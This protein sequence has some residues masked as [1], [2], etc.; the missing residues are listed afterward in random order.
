M[1][2]RPE[3]AV[4]HSISV[5]APIDRAF[6]VFT[7]GFG[8][9][10]PPEHNLL[11]VPIAETVLEAHVGGALLDRGM[12]G[13][14]CRWGRVLAFEPPT[15][16]VFSWDISPAW[17]IETDPDRTSEVEV[18]FV[19]EGPRHTRVVL[20]HRHLER[21]GEGWEGLRHGVDG[22][23]GWPLYLDRYAA[24]CAGEG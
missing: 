23:Q 1:T 15:R 4:R 16:L 21:H 24:L 11:G 2:E 7:E 13:S 20:E 19:A 12:D 22:D 18:T 10:K 9:F 14:E 5:A 6:E 3:T 17:Q 8:R